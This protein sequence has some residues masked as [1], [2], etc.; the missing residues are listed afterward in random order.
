MLFDEMRRERH[1]ERE[2]GEGGGRGQLPMRVLQLL[3]GCILRETEIYG[4]IP[5]LNKSNWVAL[6][7]AQVR[8]LCQITKCLRTSSHFL[9]FTFS[10]PPQLER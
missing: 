7:P 5:K 8:D 1:R 3:I 10:C 2:R 4:A 9:F 6:Q